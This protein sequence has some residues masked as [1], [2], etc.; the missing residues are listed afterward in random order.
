LGRVRGKRQHISFYFIEGLKGKEEDPES[1]MIIIGN[2]THVVE[3]L[4]RAAELAKKDKH[5]NIWIDY[6]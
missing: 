2:N 3:G 6:I 1:K 5:L 4:M